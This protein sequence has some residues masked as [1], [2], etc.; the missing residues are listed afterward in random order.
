LSAKSETIFELLSAIIAG[1][2]TDG[3]AIIRDHY[4]FVSPAASD[5]KYT[6][7]QMMKVFMRDGFIDRYSGE[8]LVFPPVLRLISNTFPKEFP[9][10]PNWKMNECHIAYW[11][12]FPTIDHIVPVA[13]GGQDIESNW[14]AT[15]MLR[16]S[17]KANWTLEELGWKLLPE[18]D[19]NIWDG[20]TASFLRYANQ[21]PEL[22]ANPFASKWCKAA[23]LIKSG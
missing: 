1:R 18:G 19:T 5:R 21:H 15:S 10:H 20:L 8:Q 2:Q 13:R 16:N 11:E 17:A 14:I 7:L 9:F 3:P 12:L 6:L 4:P 22:L 23:R